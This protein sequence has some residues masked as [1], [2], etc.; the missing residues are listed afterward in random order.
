MSREVFAAGLKLCEELGHGAFLGGG[1]PTDHPRFLEFL[2]DVLNSDVEMEVSGVITNGSNEKF[3]LLLAKLSGILYVALSTTE[4]HDTSLVS[5]KVIKTFS[6]NG[7]DIRKGPVAVSKMGRGK[8]ISG[9]RKTCVCSDLWMNW[10][11]D[12]YHCG[13]K[14]QKYGNILTGYSFPADVEFG[15]CYSYLKKIAV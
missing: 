14:K 9:S 8:N 4:Y 10:N 13:C 2:V 11:G 15:E 6:R 7:I 5:E 12:L 1:E 3:A